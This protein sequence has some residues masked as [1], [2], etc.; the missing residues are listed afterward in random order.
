MQTNTALAAV[1]DFLLM[2]PPEKLVNLLSPAVNIDTL[3]I[4]V[5]T[6]AFRIEVRALDEAGTLVVHG[7]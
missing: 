7:P 3:K 1:F 4:G 2:D 5:S 6:G